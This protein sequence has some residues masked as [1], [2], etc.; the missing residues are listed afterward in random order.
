MSARA[1]AKKVLP[2]PV[3][4]RVVYFREYWLEGEWELRELQNLTPERGLAIDVGANVGLYSYALKRIGHHVVSFEPDQ[5]YQ[6][7][8]R[9]LLGS[10]ARIEPVA[11]SSAPGTGVMRVPAFGAFYGGV[12]ASL[13]DYV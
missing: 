10:D 11:L 13:S 6:K 9:A 3:W 2:M 1:L 8:L 5:T 4:A 12:R 7:R